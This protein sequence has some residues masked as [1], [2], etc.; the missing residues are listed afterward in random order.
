M[1]REFILKNGTVAFLLPAIVILSSIWIT[2]LPLF[3]FSPEL[4]MAITYDLTVLSPILYLIAI[5][6]KKISK[7]TVVP[8]FILGLVIAN[9]LLPENQRSHYNI[10]VNYIFPI[11]ELGVVSTILYTIYKIRKAFWQQEL[12]NFD[13]LTILN[14]ASFEILKN[15]KLASVISTEVSM[16]YYGL[17]SWKTNSRRNTYSAYKKNSVGI[18]LGGI[19]FLI[20]VETIAVHVFLIRY[21]PTLTWILTIGSIYS[22]LQIFAHIKAIYQRP[23]FIDGHLIHLRNG[24]FGDVNTSIYNIKSITIQKRQLD[25]KEDFQQLAFLPGLE[26][27]NLMIEFKEPVTINKVYGIQKQT[28]K[29]VFYLDNYEMLI[30]ELNERLNNE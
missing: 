8:I 13:F 23:S 26:S 11:A 24:L 17:I 14:Q 10:V 20:M 4:T 19:I 27:H 3:A 25:Q 7:I 9:F 1:N 16:F 2:Q 18:I 21:Y 15:Q 29:V 30:S 5:W 12:Q 6:K 22:G 28:S